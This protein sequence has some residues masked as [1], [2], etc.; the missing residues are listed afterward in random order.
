MKIPKFQLE[1]FFAR[2]EFAAPYLLCA[3]DIEGWPMAELLALADEETR[4]LWDDLS[5]GYTE[6]AGH[7][8]LRREIAS[9]YD[10]VA[11]EEVLVFAGAEEA[12]FV[13]LNVV[14]GPGDH[15][16]VTWPGYQ[17]LHEVARA[18]GAEVDLLPLDPAA[19]WALDLDRVRAL[20][21]PTTRA[22]AVNFPHNPTGAL[23]DAATWQALVGLAHEAGVHLFCDEVYRFLEYAPADRLPAAV[24]CDSRGVSLGVMSKSLAL[25]GLRIGWIA[26][27]DAE[28]LHR[29]A[30]FKDY[31]TICNSAPSEILALIALRARERVLARSRGILERNLEHLDRFFRDWSGTFDWVRPRAGSVS[32]PRLL[33]DVPIEYLTTELV[34]AEGVLLL[35]GSL[36]G[37]P[38]NHFRLGFGRTNLPDALVRLERFAARRLANR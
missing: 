25:A 37:Y 11:P 5:L 28:L 27:H 23:P 31:T 21:R 38:A 2:W 10:A 12:I 35:P 32:F 22:I 29:L 1:R 17:S 14:L 13:S 7:P 6:A 33:A 36:F 18:A 9:L 4:A 16:L 34:E 15:A 20:L 30:A 26:T 3:S 8:L 19:G 24:D